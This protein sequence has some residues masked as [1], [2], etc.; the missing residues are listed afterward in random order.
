MDIVLPGVNMMFES[1][2]NYQLG[3]G[4]F[5]VRAST[6][7]CATTPYTWMRYASV[8]VKFAPIIGFTHELA[9]RLGIAEKFEPAFG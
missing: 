8:Q 2:D 9:K 3:C 5:Y 1:R 7:V 6:T 4:Q